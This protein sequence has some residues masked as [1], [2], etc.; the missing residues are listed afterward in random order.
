MRTSPPI[1][2]DA[3]ADRAALAAAG[4]KERGLAI[5]FAI[6][7]HNIPEG[8]AV[9]MPIYA[10]TKS[11]WM[12][13]KWCILSSLCEPFAAG[14]FGVLTQHSYTPDLMNALNAMVSQRRSSSQRA[15]VANAALNAQ[16]AGIMIMLCIVELMPAT[17]EHISARSAA[18]THLIGQFVM[19]ASLHLLIKYGGH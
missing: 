19:F 13:M 8:M 17:L 9:A 6:A 5:T 2:C 12:A 10:S 3:R 14:V 15:A 18:I 11:K 4:V 7:L 16:V 1:R